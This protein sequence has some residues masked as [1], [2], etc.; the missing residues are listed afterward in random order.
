MVTTEL[1]FNICPKKLELLYRHLEFFVSR[2]IV[3]FGFN[4]I[5][6]R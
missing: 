3:L 5:N 1:I 4:I 2:Y 6:K